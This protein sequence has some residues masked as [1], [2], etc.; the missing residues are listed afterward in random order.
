MFSIFPALG[1]QE[2]DVFADALTAANPVKDVKKRK[3]RIS[4]TSSSSSEPKKNSVP[5]SP[6]KTEDSSKPVLKVSWEKENI[7]FI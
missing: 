2:S 1:L 6:T 7:N 5:L 3:R 4:N